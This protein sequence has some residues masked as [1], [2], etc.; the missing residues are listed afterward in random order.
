[1]AATQTVTQPP[2]ACNSTENVSLSKISVPRSG[3]VTLFGYPIKV[4]VERGH[5]LLED[6][7]GPDRRRARLSR[8]GHGLERLVVIGAD[9]FV[10]LSALRWLADQDAAFVMLDRDGSVLATTGPVRPSDAKLRRAQALAHTSDAALRIARELIAH[11]LSGQ[12]SVARCKLLDSQTARTIAQYR[13]ELD[14]AET[15]SAVRSI[16]AQAAAVYWSVWRNL[17]INFP[18]SDLRR[19]P[20]HWRKFGSRQSP[21]TGSC[22]L[23]AN[24]ANA[25][26]NYL[27]ALL[28]SE[29]RLAVAALGLDPGLGVLHVDT[30]SRDSLACDVME[31]VRPQIDAY[32]LDWITHESFSREWFF[33]QRDGNCRLMAPF[34]VRLG[35][36][37]RTWARAVAPFAEWIA[38]GFSST[39]RKSMRPPTRLTQGR[40]REARGHSPYLPVTSPPSPERL[41]VGCGKSI[42]SRHTHC[43]DCFLTISTKS[44]VEAAKIGRIAAQ[45]DVAQSSRAET[46]RRNATA[47]HAWSPATHPAWLTEEA[48]SKEIQPQLSRFANGV[49]ASTLQVSMS[50]AADVRKGRRRPHQRHWQSLAHLVGIT[51]NGKK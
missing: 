21:L 38:H 39:T 31:P 35:Q 9:G 6:G 24:P 47:Q 33:E 25:I 45:S 15:I 20:E 2:S 41:C 17:V 10:S 18:K 4:T 23:A 13:G 28:E 30:P 11:K 27:Y 8:V 48:Y 40:R 36:T 37:A 51:V 5:L 43:A 50:Y 1:M 16:E 44:L 19:V 29:A 26:L 14:S 22:R 34:A 32:L 7:V 42:S 12:E 49:I 46:Q 3:V